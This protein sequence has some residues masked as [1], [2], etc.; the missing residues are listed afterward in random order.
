MPLIRAE[1]LRPH[2]LGRTVLIHDPSQVL[3]LPFDH[4]DGSKARDRS[5]YNNHGVVYGATR[6]AGKIGSALSF[7]GVDDY[8]GISNIPKPGAQLTFEIW[9]KIPSGEISNYPNIVGWQQPRLYQNPPPSPAN[10]IRL[11][12]R[13]NTTDYWFEI[14]DLGF[15]TWNHIVVVM[16][17]EEGKVYRY[18]NGASLDPYTTITGTITYTDWSAPAFRIGGSPAGCRPQTNDEVRI[19]NRALSQAEIRRVMNLR[20]I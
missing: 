20:G 1:F 11:Y 18:L 7:D 12:Y 15:Y 2:Q 17:S 4:D 14:V 6:V 10:T 8:V 13:V 3:Y 19:Y 16:N 5:G 9:L